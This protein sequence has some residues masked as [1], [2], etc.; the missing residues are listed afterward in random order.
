MPLV[1][2][3]TCHHQLPLPRSI[4]VF[5]R[6][7]SRRIERFRREHHV[8]AFVPG[9]FS[10]VYAALLAL[11]DSKNLSGNWFCEWGSGFGV[12]TCLAAMLGYEARGIEIENELVD[13]A[14]TLAD[15][16]GVDVEFVQGS[17]IPAGGDIFA[18]AAADCAWMT[19]M[20]GGGHEALGLDPADFDVIFAYPWPDEEHLTAALFDSYARDGA[21]LVTDHEAGG[22]RLRRRCPAVPSGLEEI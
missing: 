10:R 6:E 2:L 11:E 17:F 8:P 22:L 16:F 19:G 20:A 12:T 4:R 1:D 15:D 5:I 3:P 13:A 18:D 14:R 7:A 21:I 9:D